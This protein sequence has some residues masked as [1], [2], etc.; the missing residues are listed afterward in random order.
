MSVVELGRL[1]YKISLA[2]DYPYM[3]TISIYVEGGIVNG[4]IGVLKNIK[5]LSENEHCAELEA[6]DKP[7]TSVST[8]K[9]R[10]RLSNT[11]RFNDQML[12]NTVS[13]LIS[14]SEHDPQITR[15]HTFI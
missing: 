4:T 2:L 11:T 14:V 13:F 1:P 15:R 5:L 12:P 8:H 7:S 3:I 9:Q 6:Q 10:L